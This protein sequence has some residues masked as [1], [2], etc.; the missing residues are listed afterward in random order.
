MA[1]SED[2]FVPTYS[3]MSCRIQ[4]VKYRELVYGLSSSHP[5]ECT[6]K[7]V[8]VLEIPAKAF[9]P[10][11]CKKHSSEKT[12]RQTTITI[13]LCGGKSISFN[14]STPEDSVAKLLRC[15]EQN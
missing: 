2:F 3:L 1:S 12:V 15:L 8:N 9:K 11:V 4:K 7:N 5:T 10:A 6:S 13:N 14:T